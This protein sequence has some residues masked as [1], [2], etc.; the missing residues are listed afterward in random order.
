[1]KFSRLLALTLFV[2][3]AMSL[4]FSVV[5]AQDA[6]LVVGWEQEPD[7][8]YPLSNSAFA[9]YFSNFYSRDAWDW[10]GENRE[11][12][13]IMVEAIPSPE[14][15]L[16]TTVPV[17]GDF[18]GD[19]TEEEAEAPVVTYKLHA[20][21]VWSDGKPVTADDC[22]FYYNLMMQ[23]DAVDSFQRGFFPDV[24]ASAEKVDDLTVKL[25]YN[26][27]WPDYTN[28]ATLSCGYPAH[29]FLGDN[30]EGFTMDTD[31]DGVFDANVDEAPYF[32]A[33]ASMDPAELVGY[34]PYILESFSVGQSA[35]FVAN[36]NWGINEW[37]K[38]PAFGTVITQFIIESA[39]MEN[40]MQ[41]GDIDVAYNF[42]SVTNGYTTME[43]VGTF[44]VPGVFFDAIWMNSGPN[45]FPA[46][47]DARVR[48]ALVSAIDRRTIAD[49]FAGPGTGAQ[50]TTSYYAPQFTNPETGFREYD[51]EKARALLTEAGWVDDDADEAA[52]NANPTPRI[53]QGV[54]GVPDGTTLVLRFYTSPVVPRPDI[55][56][57]IQGY[58]NQVGVVTQLF[59]VN[60]PTVLFASFSTR[61]ILNTGN[62]DLAMYALSNSVLSPNGSPDNFSCGGIASIENP[63]GRNSTWFCN[64]EHDKLD[65]QIA[66]TNDPAAR[67]ELAYQRD[68]LFF[69]AAVWHS[70][71]PRPVAWAVRTDRVNLE[72]AAPNVGTLSSNYFQS[73]E[74]WEPAS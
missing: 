26:K 36:P 24:V 1:M 43:N 72:S 53:S 71:R 2:V 32:E 41:V 60:G 10:K 56:T 62:Y 42:N 11:I 31:G 65:K 33:F 74:Y 50:L 28:D 15:G 7:V 9:G 20:G 21:M 35:T 16:V 57:V 34:G 27:P 25:T 18:D 40:A 46:M 23:P 48:E 13:P 51:V 58:L 69:D 14:N 47:Q 38:A 22:I 6:T 63:E 29:K 8:P 52:D 39:Q 3:F 44:I 19:G 30:A 37:E 17:T 4:G 66:I 67:L 5:S 45:A 54:A 49:Q 61:G 73:I 55:Q 59:V 12:F 70:I 64:E 68:L